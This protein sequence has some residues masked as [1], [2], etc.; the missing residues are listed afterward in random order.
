MSA[1]KQFFLLLFLL[2]TFQNALAFNKVAQNREDLF[3]K[4]NKVINESLTIRKKGISLLDYISPRLKML[5]SNKVL[6]GND[7][8]QIHNLFKQADRHF[9]KAEQLLKY[10]PIKM[11]GSSIL[12]LTAGKSYRKVSASP[13]DWIMGRPYL[14]HTYYIN[15]NDSLGEFYLATVKMVEALELSNYDNFMLT[16]APYYNIG[17]LRRLINRDNIELLGSLDRMVKDFTGKKRIHFFKEIHF[18]MEKS[19]NKFVY[20]GGNEQVTDDHKYLKILINNSYSYNNLKKMLDY[21]KEI[22]SVQF[23]NRVID[24]IANSTNGVLGKLSSYFGNLIGTIQMRHGKLYNMSSSKIEALRKKLKPLD[25]LMDKTP[26]RLTDF[27]IPGYWGH[28]AIWLGTESELKEI[29]IWEKL[30]E[31]EARA[32][33]HFGYEGISFQHSIRVG[34]NIVEALRPGVQINSLEH[35]LDIDDF[36]VIRPTQLTES[37]KEIFLINALSQTGKDYDFNF[38]IETS[39]TIVCTELVY[40]TYDTYPW[41]TR[42]SFGR[43]TINPDQVAELGLNENYFEILMMY[44]DGKERF[45]NLNFLM[46]SII[47]K[48]KSYQPQLY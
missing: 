4:F 15:P 27:F 45:G 2:F 43:Y 34:Q 38:D 14:K 37:E 8:V 11:D 32:R 26:Y 10:L 42:S 46:S 6:T 23:Q 9:K 20:T 22:S 17:P 16:F 21:S 48:S 47:S 33:Q 19:I 41:E 36:A 31:L 29:G 28:V 35:F 44:I 40:V 39:K 13:I 1:M 30:P 7:I 5:P 18:F 12:K 25:I 3:V 24:F